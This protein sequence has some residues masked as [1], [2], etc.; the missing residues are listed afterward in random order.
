MIKIAFGEIHSINETNYT[1]VV[2]LDESDGILTGDLQ[3]ATPISYLNKISNIPHPKTPCIVL[4]FEDSNERGVVIGGRFSDMNTCDLSKGKK[5]INYQ[6]SKI[7]INEDGTIELECKDLIIKTKTIEVT[8]ETIDVV[9]EK[10]KVTSETIDVAAEKIKV[11]SKTIDIT[12]EEIKVT[13]ETIDLNAQKIGLNAPNITMGT[14][15]TKTNSAINV[16]G[17]LNITELLTLEKGLVSSGGIKITEGG[18]IEA[19]A[20]IKTTGIITARSFVETL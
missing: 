4:L 8:S 18:S 20:E 10:I 19:N 14:P 2:K 1:A 3:I 12:G 9:A 15:A 13:S 7:T 5:I 17:A 16:E 11:T 6:K